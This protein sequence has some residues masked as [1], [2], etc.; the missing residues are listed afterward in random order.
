MKAPNEQIAKA[1]I[2]AGADINAV[3][4]NGDTALSI[5]Q[6]A[7]KTDI[8]DLLKKAGAK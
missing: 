5:A 6:G 2:S 1:L 4:D 3:N 8:V 7:G